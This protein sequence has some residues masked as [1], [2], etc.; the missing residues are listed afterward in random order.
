LGA[1][2]L[3]GTRLV[4]ACDKLA[5]LRDIVEDLY[6]DG[7]STLARFSGGPSGV[8]W[9]YSQLQQTL[10]PQVPQVGPEF[11]RLLD[12]AKELAGGVSA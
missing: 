2:D 1:T 10:M 8:L 5:N 6:S 7:P 3:L 12:V 4:E 9:Y 11:G